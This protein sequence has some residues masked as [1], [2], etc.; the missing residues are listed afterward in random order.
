[1]ANN[2][3]DISK[4]NPATVF[5]LVKEWKGVT[6]ATDWLVKHACRTLLKQ[7]NAEVM[8]LFDFS[9][10]DHIKISNFQILTPVVKIGESLEFTFQLTNASASKSRI[11]LE[12]GLY[13]QKA[14]GTL[15]KKVFKVSEKT[16]PENSSNT[17]N[18][19]HSFKVI[20]TRKFHV[21]KHQLSIIING[22][23]LEK[24]NFKLDN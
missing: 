19:K 14:N 15:S 7:G 17:I 13:Y 20:T 2:L 16:Y 4:D 21:G 1:V 3:N 9:S 23:E 8:Q 11:R 5:D 24:F 6:I 10:V 22:N 18:R 12:Y